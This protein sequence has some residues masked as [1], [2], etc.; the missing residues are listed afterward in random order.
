MMFKDLQSE[1]RVRNGETKGAVQAS[2]LVECPLPGSAGILA[3]GFE[4]VLL[5]ASSA[6][7]T[8]RST[9]DVA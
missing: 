5:S 6:I 9:K 2:G 3:G 7:P 4:G 1:A 8:T